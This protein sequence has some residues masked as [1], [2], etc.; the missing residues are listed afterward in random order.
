MLTDWT[1]V[2][3]LLRS[4]MTPGKFPSQLVIHEK[5]CLESSRVKAGDTKS[6]SQIQLLMCL[7]CMIW[8][9]G[10]LNVYTV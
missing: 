5:V 10:P 8:A 7:R 4:N 1:T 6:V 2:P 3:A 9:Q